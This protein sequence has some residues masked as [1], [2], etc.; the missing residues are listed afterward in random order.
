MADKAAWRSR[1][2]QAQ[3][4]FAHAIQQFRPYLE[5]LPEGPRALDL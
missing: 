4:D 5:D 2:Q 1:E 3:A